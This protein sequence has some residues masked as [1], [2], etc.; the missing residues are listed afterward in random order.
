MDGA[1]LRTWMRQPPSNF[2]DRLVHLGDFGFTGAE[3]SRSHISNSRREEL[4]SVGSAPS[5]APALIHQSDACDHTPSLCFSQSRTGTSVADESASTD[6][7]GLCTGFRLLEDNNGVLEQPLDEVGMPKYECLFW[8]LKCGY[9][10]QDREEWETHC[11]SHFYGEEPPRSVSCPLCDWEE[12]LDSGS[13]AWDLKM[14]H[15]ADEHFQY[16]QNLS[17]SRPD[18]HLFTHLWQK[19]LIDDQDL[20]ELKGGNHNLSHAPSNFVTTGGP[21]SRR[22]RAPGRHRMQH[23]GQGR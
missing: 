15:I 1:M 16:G 10:S 22:E 7:V 13:T 11:L 5:M 21:G 6:L 12:S 23:I 4:R 19:R 14:K 9:L 2:N 20:K 3:P 17:A 8:F 18:F